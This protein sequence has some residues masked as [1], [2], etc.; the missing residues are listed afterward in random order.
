MGKIR[1]TKYTSADNDTVSE[2]IERIEDYIALLC[3]ELE[4]ILNQ[5]NRSGEEN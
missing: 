1:L 2:R 5:L 3:M 4:Y